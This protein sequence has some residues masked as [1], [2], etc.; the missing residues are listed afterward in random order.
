MGYTRNSDPNFYFTH[1]HTT[2]CGSYALRIKEWYEVD[3]DMQDRAI[4][5][6][7]NGIDDREIYEIITQEAVELMLHEFGDK[8]REL[9]NVTDPIADNEELIAFRIGGLDDWSGYDADFHFRVFRDGKWME[10]C[11][12]NEIQNCIFEEDA[13]ETALLYEGP[14]VYLAHRID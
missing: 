2:N 12:C 7:S 10:K 14:I 8:M 3:F 4:E 11:G 6:S 1:E 5:L 9:V 13:W